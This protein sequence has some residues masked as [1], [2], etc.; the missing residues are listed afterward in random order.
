MLDA[1][2]PAVYRETHMA[3][4][5]TVHVAARV[6]TELAI[7]FERAALSKDRTVSRALRRVMRQY[8]SEND[9][10]RPDPATA[11]QTR[12]SQESAHAG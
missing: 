9:N 5:P 8:V 12:S 1:V 3:G 11:A 10:G 7:D 2:G 6:P 4:T